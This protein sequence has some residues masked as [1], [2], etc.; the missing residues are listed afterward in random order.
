MSANDRSCDGTNLDTKGSPVDIISE[1]QIVR[2]T[3]RAAD[4]ERLHQVILQVRLAGTRDPD[5]WAGLHTVRG[6]LHKLHDGSVNTVHVTRGG[7]VVAGAY[8]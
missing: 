3:E 6:C 4:L 8:R 2:V 1:K 7:T 5:M